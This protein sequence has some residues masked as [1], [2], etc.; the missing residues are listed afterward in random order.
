MVRI[1]KCG[2]Q[3]AL[4]VHINMNNCKHHSV[5]KVKSRVLIMCH[6]LLFL[7]PVSFCFSAALL[8]NIHNAQACIRF[9]TRFPEGVFYLVQGSS[10]SSSSSK[11]RLQQC[12]GQMGRHTTASVQLLGQ[13]VNRQNN[14]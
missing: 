4:P 9:V 5:L 6:E 11:S 7:F 10:L 1:R 13:A 3:K 14:T 8:W 12:N 2:R